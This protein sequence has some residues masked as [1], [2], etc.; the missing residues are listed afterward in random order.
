[1]IAKTK[2]WESYVDGAGRRHWRW[3][4]TP[5]PAADASA[6][7]TSALPKARSLQPRAPLLPL[8]VRGR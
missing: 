6:L 2:N 7:G 5:R 8:R 3:P 1:M 4:A